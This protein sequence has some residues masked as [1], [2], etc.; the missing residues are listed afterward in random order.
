MAFRGALRRTYTWIA[1]H[2]PWSA[3]A[4]RNT[5]FAV[6]AIPPA[7]PAALG[8]ASKPVW[9][10]LVLVLGP[11][12][13]SLQRSRFW[14]LLGLDVPEIPREHSW[15]SLRGLTERV[16]SE[17]TWRQY[18]YHFLVSPLAGVAGALLVLTW[19]GG[20]AA[21]TVYGWGVM[22]LDARTPGWADYDVIT[23]SGVL[24][25][26]AAPWLAA[27][28]T[29]LDAIAAAALLGPNR[30][31]ELERRVEDLAE[32]RAG[33]LDAAD[34]ERRRIERDLHDGAQQRLVAL[35]MNLGIARATLKVLPPEAKAVIDEAHREA[36]EA[37]EELSNL[38]RGLHPAVLED[39][40]LDA[41]LSG[42]AARAPLPVELSVDIGARPGPT[43]EAVAYFVVS[44]ALA[45][46]AKHARARHCSVRVSRVSGR[47]PGDR[48][49]VTVT[50]DGAGGA[51][52]V[53]G[54]GLVGL[55]KRVGSVDGTIMINSPLGGPTVITVELPCGL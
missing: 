23:A 28:L 31:Q 4:W 37:I 12:L 55:R 19:A 10:L 49:R 50:D 29:R 36:K 43:V 39:R 26:L 38:V 44:E 27:L 21:A 41:A 46:V 45:N 54:T 52:P 48:L 2:A 30:A 7:L 14:S 51:D 24:L 53:R 40:G 1:A 5:A 3:W 6:A 25:L 20:A 47:R 34:L 9:L 13:S 33:V 42:I 17:A 18:C 15:S 35:A 16:R 11:L 32:S 22:P 8:F